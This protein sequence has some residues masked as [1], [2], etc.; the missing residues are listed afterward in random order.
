MHSYS[1]IHACMY[2]VYVCINLSKGCIHIYIPANYLSLR[3]IT[4]LLKPDMLH[5]VS[6]EAYCCMHVC[7]HALVC[8]CVCVCVC[9]LCVHVQTIKWKPRGPKVPCVAL[10]SQQWTYIVHAHHKTTD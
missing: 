3:T 7:M 5:L 1:H 8:E 10:V 6:R 2:N 4:L 9:V